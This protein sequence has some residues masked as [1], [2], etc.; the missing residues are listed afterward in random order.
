[1]ISNL[2]QPPKS[3]NSNIQNSQIIKDTSSTVQNCAKLFVCG[4]GDAQRE[5]FKIMLQS[6]IQCG[7]SVAKSYNVP[8]NEFVAEVQKII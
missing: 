7:E 6:G 4:M 3:K 5:R 8:L 2:I 1:M